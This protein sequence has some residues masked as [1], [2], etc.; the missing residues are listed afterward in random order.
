[1]S[2]ETAAYLRWLKSDEPSVVWQRA[3]NAM[4]GTRRPFRWMARHLRIDPDDARAWFALA[5]FAPL[6]IDGRWHIAAAVPAPDPFTDPMPGDEVVVVDPE[7]KTAALLGEPGP[8]LILP[9]PQGA[10]LFVH[11]DPMAWLREWADARVVYLETRRDSIA[12]SRIVPRFNGEPP[13]ALAIGKIDEISWAGILAP[14]IRADFENYRAIRRAI[15]RAAHLPR[16]EA[17]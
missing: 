14:T 16:V 3:H 13:S 4:L 6:E 11:T 9:H 1:M 17:A 12:R 15:F 8:A 10:S 5:G 7:A 2:A